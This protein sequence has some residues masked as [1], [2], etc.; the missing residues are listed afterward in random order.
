MFNLLGGSTTEKVKN[1]TAII[2]INSEKLKN[3]QL[4]AMN[5]IKDN[6]SVPIFIYLIVISLL[7]I[8]AGLWYKWREGRRIPILLRSLE[9]YPKFLKVRP[10][11]SLNDYRY[12]KK[13]Y[14]LCDWY[15]SSSYRSFLPGL[16]YYDYCSVKAIEYILLSGVRFISLDI[17]NNEH[18]GDYEP[19]V[20]VGDEKGNW[21]YTLNKITF[22]DCCRAI[23]DIAFSKSAITNAEDPFFLCLNLYVNKN[24][25]TLNKI[26]KILYDIFQERLL[27]KRYSYE[28]TNLVVEPI[29]NFINK[30]IIIS[31]KGH[32]GS[33][34]SELINLSWQGP[35]LRKLKHLEAIQTHNPKELIDYN[36]LNMSYVYPDFKERETTNY[37]PGLPWLYGCQF[38]TMNFQKLDNN[39]NSYVNKFKR[40]SFVLKPYNLR[41]HKK[42]YR[43]PK[44][45]TPKLYYNTLQMKSQ[46][47]N[48]KI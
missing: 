45:Q 13:P 26:T 44:K 16:Q 2:T 32:T 15:V 17:F 33:K 20:T 24:S 23:R 29:N 38:V 48:Y 7:L 35:F 9:V 6:M 40:Q 3:A 39:M 1:I 11:T 36:R 4:S 41:Y 21:H 34:L 10:L 12:V 18:L 22:Y 30:I 14:L 5:S 43:K 19:I 37:A 28:Q 42:Y 27:D 8:S 31:G 46:F 25:K 47:Y